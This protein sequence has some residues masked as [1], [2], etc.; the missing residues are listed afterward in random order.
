M[1]DIYFSF[2]TED[3]TSSRSCDAVRDEANLLHEYGVRGNFNVVGYLAREFVR[4]RRTDV[5]DA[6]KHHTISFHSLRHTYHPTICEYTDTESYEQAR[7][8]FERQEDMGMGMVMAA[9]GV[10]S[11]PAAVPPGDSLSYAAMYGYADR[12]VPLY[13]GS[14]FYQEDGTGVYYCNGFHN[15]YD[16][17]L[18]ELLFD[19]EFDAAELLDSIAG[20]RRFVLYHHPNMAVYREFWDKYNYNGEN[21]HPMYEWAEPPRRTDEEVARFFANLRVLLKALRADSRF[22]IC[23]MDALRDEV[24]TEMTSR[25]V[26]FGMLPEIRAAL[27]ESFRWTDAPVSLSV[28]DCFF[29][30]RHFLF[31]KAPYHPGKVHGFLYEPEG[32]QAPVVLDAD[33]VRAAAAGISPD[34]FLPPYFTVSG[35]RIG[36]ADLLFAMLDAAMGAESVT[37]QPR[38]QQCVYEEAYPN[39]RDIALK[40]SWLHADTFE[41]RYL[42]DRLRLQ[43][44]TLR[45][46][47]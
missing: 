38:R 46:E 44:W 30:A 24:V 5:L 2:D 40:G 29:A 35:K 10:D 25:T 42:S 47:R 3:F 32:V 23:S 37:V 9:C 8:E 21:Q 17:A 1:T 31:S 19:P 22:R 34:E 26:D 28:A 4:N 12:N 14:L 15:Q 16:W 41:D 45:P 7:A 13:L 43:A 6:L 18:E 33:A 20:R 36:P 11:F 27:S 39:L